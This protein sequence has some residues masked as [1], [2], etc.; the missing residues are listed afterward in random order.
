MEAD[1]PIGRNVHTENRRR[2]DIIRDEEFLAGLDLDTLR[3][4]SGLSDGLGLNPSFYRRL[5]HGRMDPLAFEVRRR[6]GL[7]TRSLIEAL[8]EILGTDDTDRPSS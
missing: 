3:E 5:L 4:R 8:P 1:E 7:E 6:S 2:I